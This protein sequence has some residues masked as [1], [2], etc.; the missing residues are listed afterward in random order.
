[1]L[2]ELHPSGR[3]NR[4]HLETSGR[5]RV[6]RSTGPTRAKKNPP[7][8]KRRARDLGRRCK[9]GTEVP[10]PYLSNICSLQWLDRRRGGSRGGGGRPRWGG[11]LR[12]CLVLRR[13]LLGRGLTVDCMDTGVR[14]CSSPRMAR[15]VRA[16]H[17]PRM[18]NRRAS[19][20]TDDSSSDGTDRPEHHDT[21]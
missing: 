1:M 7:G 5:G 14:A 21:R 17:A 13:G 3:R 6:C 20:I 4:S 10:R 19:R 9:C 11:R 18:R 15:R 2:L 8:V 12:S 16:A